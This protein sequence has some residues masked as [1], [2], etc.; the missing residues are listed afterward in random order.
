MVESRPVARL[1]HATSIEEQTGVI[2]MWEHSGSR[3]IISETAPKR[4]IAAAI[5]RI[6]AHFLAVDRVSFYMI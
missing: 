5:Y 4:A 2:R 6:L 1:L 3:W